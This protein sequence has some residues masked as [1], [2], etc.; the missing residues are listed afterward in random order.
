MIIDNIDIIYFIF[1]CVFVDINILIYFRNSK[2]K[3]D[4]MQCKNK[5]YLFTNLIS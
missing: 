1:V 4:K 5:I 3:K 2:G